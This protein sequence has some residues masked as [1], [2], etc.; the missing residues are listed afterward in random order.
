VSCSP[1]EGQASTSAA[2]KPLYKYID[3]QK[4]AGHIFHAHLE[5]LLLILAML[6]VS[7]FFDYLANQIAKEWAASHRV[8]VEGGGM[9]NHLSM[10]CFIW[11]I[12][13]M[14]EILHQLIGGLS[15]YV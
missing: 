10:E 3:I 6:V 1:N 12:L 15:H 9:E 4:R 8:L 7:N 5:S 13:W 14:E 2:H 11:H